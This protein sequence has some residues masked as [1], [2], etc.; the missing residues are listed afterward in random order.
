[1]SNAETKFVATPDPQSVV[2]HETQYP[3]SI[4]EA[5]FK[6]SLSIGQLGKSEVNPF[7][8]FP[9]V[10]IDK[11]YEIVA[12]EALTNGLSWTCKEISSVL[13]GGEPTKPIMKFTYMFTLLG[14]DGVCV[15]AA[16]VIS[17]FHQ[18][19]GAQTAG[20]AASYAEKLFMRKM[21]KVVT[22]EVDADATDPSVTM[23]PV[24]T[25][26]P[27]EKPGMVVVPNVGAQEKIDAEAANLP[28]APEDA[29]DAGDLA[30]AASVS[31]DNPEDKADVAGE[32][33]DVEEVQPGA[34]KGNGSTGPQSPYDQYLI[35]QDGFKIVGG[36]EKADPEK[37]W[38][39]VYNCFE[40][41]MPTIDEAAKVKEWWDRNLTVLEQVE[42]K[43]PEVHKRITAL[44]KEHY[45]KLDKEKADG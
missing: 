28:T 11:Y 38:D 19:Q 10:P 18:F 43:A 22:G 27:P 42:D 37:K 40:T 4:A 14:R 24:P 39:I 15:P 45:I 23:V 44:F 6:V 33:A 17:I 2:I 8:K 20:S 12:H 32:T 41:F 30:D 29:T 16:D 5:I 3:Q 34:A 25:V 26:A 9:Y 21:F 1:M 31:P 36:L 13:V 35:E 7:G